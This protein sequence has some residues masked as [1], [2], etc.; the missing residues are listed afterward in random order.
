VEALRS[1]IIS[2]GASRRVVQ[3]RSCHRCGSILSCGAVHLLWSII[4]IAQTLSILAFR[5]HPKRWDR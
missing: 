2:Q 3:V 1:F 5:E 4:K